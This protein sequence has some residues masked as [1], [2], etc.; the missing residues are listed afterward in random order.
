MTVNLIQVGDSEI[1][2]VEGGWEGTPAA[3][4]KM[5]KFNYDHALIEVCITDE[6]LQYAADGLCVD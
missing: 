4:E 6:L 5:T 3:A 2:K 1:L